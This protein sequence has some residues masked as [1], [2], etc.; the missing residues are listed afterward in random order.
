MTDVDWRTLGPMG[1]AYFGRM[2]A[3][4]S[5][6][7]KNSLAMINENAGLMQDLAVLAGRGQPLDPQRL[8]VAVERIARHVQ[9]ANA[10]I[11]TLNRFAHLPDEPCHTVDLRE[12]AA[13]ALGLHRRQAAQAR[14][15]LALAPGDPVPLATRPFLLAGALHLCLC[16]V[17]EAGAGPVAVD[18]AA[19]PGGG[20]VIFTG[21]GP[22]VALPAGPEADALLAALDARCALE[23]G[24]L[25]LTLARLSAIH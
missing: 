2:C 23:G 20:E 3:G 16:A 19:V 25:R 9:R 4:V 21:A 17:L 7:L 13:L 22:G 14:V 11:G 6:E 18:A 12:A 24:A 10:V 15:E 8:A 5:H 1:L